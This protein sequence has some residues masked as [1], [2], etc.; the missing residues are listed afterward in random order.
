MC[1]MPATNTCYLG[2]LPLIPK[3]GCL[4]FVQVKDFVVFKRNIIQEA[5]LIPKIEKKTC[6]RREQ[7]IPSVRLLRNITVPID[8]CFMVTLWKVFY[9]DPS[10]PYHHNISCQGQ[11][12]RKYSQ[13]NCVCK[14]FCY[15]LHHCYSLLEQEG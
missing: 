9:L 8:N 1:P 4:H 3:G 2:S 5:F 10:G 6:K 12:K 13:K 11:R 15:T 7:E 14:M